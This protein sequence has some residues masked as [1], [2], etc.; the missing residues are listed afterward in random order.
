MTRNRPLW[1]TSIL[2]LLSGWVILSLPNCRKPDI[3]FGTTFTNNNTTNVVAVDTFSVAMSTVLLDSFPTAGKGSLLIGRYRDPYFGIITS[4]TYLQVS[5]PINLPTISNLAVYDSLSL[6]L[7]IN[8]GY[9]GDTTQVQRYVVSQL[10]TVITLPGTQTT[11]YNISKFPY[12][13]NPMGYSDAQINPTAFYTSQKLNDS[14][15]IKLP[16]SQG[17]ELF[18]LMY[19]QSD[20]VRNLNTFLGYFK[21]FSIYPDPTSMGAIYGFRDTVIM[22]LYYHTPGLL[23]TPAFID[24]TLNNKPYQFNQI[25]FDRTGTPT[26]PVDSL[27]PEIPSTATN[28]AGY[29]QT[30]TG[31]MVKLRFPTITNL[32]QYPDYLT[33]LKAELT[34]RPTVGSYSPTFSLPPQISIAKT[35]A[36][37]DIGVLL[38]VGTG[39]LIVDYLYGTNTAYTYDITNFIQ[40]QILLGNE[41]N[42]Q[43]GLML[44]YPAPAGYTSFNRAVIGDQFNPNNSNKVNLKI[45]YASYY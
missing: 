30:A 2:F 11:F 15:K 25:Y 32:L 17:Q 41:Y 38:P 16:D 39:N 8:K 5:P 45:Y 24:F 9:Y 23:Y 31:L 44:I 37:N 43:N 20:T 21:G 42:S 26:A 6:I 7:R 14:L 10:Q 18:N 1:Q 3:N 35:D 28:N 19:N 13:P 22:R 34:L 33:V 29:I 36:A 12:D 27:N 4:Q 40:S